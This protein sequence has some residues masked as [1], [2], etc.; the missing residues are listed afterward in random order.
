MVETAGDDVDEEDEAAAG[1]GAGAA[2]VAMAAAVAAG[3][4][5]CGCGL[6]AA[7][8]L[9]LVGQA[10]AAV[11]AALVAKVC[12]DVRAHWLCWLVG[13]MGDRFAS[14]CFASRHLSA[15]DERLREGPG[16]AADWE[17][18]Q[19]VDKSQWT[20]APAKSLIILCP[21]NAHGR[22]DD[23]AAMTAAAH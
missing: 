6:I 21:F 10:E 16:D 15:S 22:L 11:A 18:R 17:R 14:H 19:P 7:A 8:R 2:I 1:E 5:G 3:A 12:V 4:V 13:G 9:S 23:D 20:Q